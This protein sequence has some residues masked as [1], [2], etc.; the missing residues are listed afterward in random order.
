[1]NQERK[2]LRIGAAVILCAI[3]LRLGV[4]GAFQPLTDLLRRPET[5]AFLFYLETGR[6]LRTS[7]PETAEVWARESPAPDLTEET[8]SAAAPAEFSPEDLELVELYSSRSD[9]PDLESLLLS[10]LD[11]DL[12]GASPT[13][14][15]LHT[16]A[17]ESY[18]KVPGEDYAETSDYRTTDERYNMLSVGQALADALEAGGISVIH[19]RTLHDAVS[20]NGAY[21]A[22]RETVAAYLEQYPSIR[23]VLDLHRDA[24][25]AGDGQLNTSAEVDGQ[26]SAQLMLVTGS[27]GGGYSHP[28][29]QENLSLALKLHALLEKENPGLCRHLCLRNSRYNQDLSPGMLLVEVGA[30]GDTRQEALTAVQ[31]LAEGILALSG[32]AVRA[33]STS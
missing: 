28:N 6:V 20:Y 7:D 30:A 29:W 25:D 32:G 4:N 27:D 24:A 11:W 33:D 17:T 21:T 26:P 8:A 18:T 15:I 23:L 16:H 14:L 31:A 22:A 10:P 2:A 3:V 19:D 12:T 5:A 1:M 13:V 9:D